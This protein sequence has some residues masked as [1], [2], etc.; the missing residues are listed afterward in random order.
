MDLNICGCKLVELPYLRKHLTDTHTL[1]VGERRG[2]EGIIGT[3]RE[4]VKESNI[5]CTDMDDMEPNSIVSDLVDGMEMDY[6]QED[7]IQFPE[8]VGKQGFCNQIVCI[9]VLEHFGMCWGDHSSIMDWNK[10]LAGLNKMMALIGDSS[11]GR[12]IITVPAGPPIFYGDLLPSGLPFLRRYDRQRMSI[13]R[14]FVTVRGFRVANEEF[15]YS[16]DFNTWKSCDES[17]IQE[18]YSQYQRTSPNVI[19]G[20]CIVKI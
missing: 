3:V 6:V 5:I 18:G 7:F 15:F 10:D 14:N 1:I 12:A 8:D 19:W 16:L 4:I 9:N 13:I 17:F 2:D 20:F 11:T